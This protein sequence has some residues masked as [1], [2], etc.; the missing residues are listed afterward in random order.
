LA[1]GEALGLGEEASDLPYRSI[2]N[3][4]EAVLGGKSAKGLMMSSG[5]SFG[6]AISSYIILCLVFMMIMMKSSNQF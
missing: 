2:D 5:R 4:V 1:E 6:G 3:A